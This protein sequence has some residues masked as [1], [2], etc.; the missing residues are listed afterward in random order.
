MKRHAVEW[1][2]EKIGSFWDYM[3]SVESLSPLYFTKGAGNGIARHIT[4]AL[5]LLEQ[6]KCAADVE[7]RPDDWAKTGLDGRAKCSLGRSAAVRY[8]GT[9]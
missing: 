1:T 5:D 8:I 9:K 3:S 4:R 7:T 2:P 6:K